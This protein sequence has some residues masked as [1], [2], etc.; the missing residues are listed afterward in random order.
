MAVFSCSISSQEHFQC[1]LLAYLIK[2]VKQKMDEEFWYVR[3]RVEI[4]LS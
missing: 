4:Q 2:L 3:F 1:S